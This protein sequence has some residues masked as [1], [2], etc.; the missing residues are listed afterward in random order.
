MEV[1]A[2]ALERGTP[3]RLVYR[4]RRSDDSYTW[5]ESVGRVV[6]DLEVADRFVVVTRRASHLESL[7]QSVEVER[8]LKQG[9]AELAARRQRFLTTIS[10]R[11]RTPLTSVIGMTELL[12]HRHEELEAGQRAQLLERLAANTEALRHLLEDATE[13]DRLGRSE[14]MLDRRVVD[15]REVVDEAIAEVVAEDD[16]VVN[17]VPAELRAVV[18]PRRVRR[19]VEILLGNCFSHA[20]AGA[21]VA[22]HADVDADRVA[23][24]VVDDG[25]GVP[26]PMRERVFDPFVHATVDSPDPGVGLGLYI[27]AELA[28]LH[29]GRA[30]VDDRPGGGARFHVSLPRRA[31]RAT[32]ASTGTA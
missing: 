11:A 2:E 9:Y 24:V 20:G 13:A 32:G 12:L 16:R 22:V 14:V 26:P 3:L 1:Q 5:V 10:H 27:V 8:R 31:T 7:V 28:A 19:M 29:G 15:L 23:L 18:D 21:D 6:T 17:A 30:W 25:P 4:M